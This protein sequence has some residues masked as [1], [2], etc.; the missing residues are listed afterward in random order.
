SDRRAPTPTAAAEMAVPVRAELLAQLLD[1]TRRMV[2]G[3]GR[4]LTDRRVRLE[5][6][7]R[8]LPEPVRLLEAASQR[9]D[10]WSERLRNGTQNL[11]A[12]RTAELHRLVAGLRPATL[13]S[14]LASAGERVA[15]LGERMQPAAARLIERRTE[16]L[17][18]LGLRLDSVS[19]ERVLERGFALVRDSEDRPVMNAASLTA[20][21]A[22]ALRFHDGEAQATVDGTGSAKPTTPRKP[23]A[24]KS[25]KKTKP[26]KSDQRQGTLL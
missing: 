20:G 5:G 18:A 24:K 7:A 17:E 9:L 14:E 3:M 8:G 21:D 16:R 19:Y 26:G 1:D 2:A 12:G 11:I 25:S 6:L 15:R 4:G 22:I 10:D 23:M 13:A